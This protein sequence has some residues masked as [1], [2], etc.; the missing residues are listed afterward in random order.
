[1]SEQ[2]DLKAN[3]KDIVK[4][5]VDFKP[6]VDVIPEY[7]P[8]AEDIKK[9]EEEEEEEEEKAEIKTPEIILKLGDVILITDPTNEILNN[10]VFLIEYI[11]PSKIKLI[12]SE[13]YEKTIIQIS[14][15][16]IIGDGNIQAIK[17]ISSNIEE[18]YA[19]QNDLL[20]GTWINIYFGGEIPTVIT[21]EIT[22]LEEDMIEVRTTDDDTLFINFKYQ[23]VPEDI[24]IETFEIRPAIVRKQGI[25]GEQEEQG[26]NEEEEIKEEEPGDQEINELSAL[27]EEDK[28]KAAL[29]YKSEV[30]QKLQKMMFDMSDI[31]FGDIVKVEEYVNIDKSKYRYNIE[32][33]ANDLLEEMVSS[34]PNAKRTNNVLNNI[35]IMISR[36]IQLRQISSTFDI[37]K[38]IT[39][40]I[41]RTANDKPLAEY[42]S[43]F[44]NT[45]YWILLVASNVKK[46]YPSDKKEYKRYTD[47]ELINENVQNRELNSLFRKYKTNQSIE[48]QN[49]YANLY[50]ALDPYMTPFYSINP[51]VVNNVFA[52]TDGIIIEGTVESNVNAVIDNLG[53]LYSTIVSNSQIV[54]RRFVIQR[55]N[56]GQDMLYST[57]L[58]AKNMVAHRVKLTN[59]DPISIKSILTLPEP[60]VRF[61]QINLPGS[62]LLVKANLNLH[63]LN[64]WELLKQKTDI[65]KIVIDGLDNDIEY[66]DD[67]FV[68]NIKQYMLDLT[69]YDKPTE[70]TNLDIYKIFLR[71]IVPKTRV[72]FNLVK[73]YIKGRLSLVDVV[74]YLEPFMI[75][76]ID[77]TYMQ[78]REINS[79][80]SNKIKEY[81][82][83]YKEYSIAFS[84]IKYIKSVAGR[85]QQNKGKYIYSN[86]LFNLLDTGSDMQLKMHI[87]N[88]YGLDEP[89]KMECSG[90][91]LLKKI[92][93]ADY[94]QLYNTAVAL[95][96]IQLMY[97][98][99]LNS[100]FEMDKNE[101]KVLT[102]KDKAN[103][104]CSA[105]IIAKKY[106]SKDAMLADDGKPI[107]FDKEYD[108][109]NYE[110]IEEKYKTQRD[111]LSSEEFIIFL[112]DEFVNKHKMDEKPAEH[113]ATTLVN[114]AKRVREGDY[115]IL[116]NVVEGNYPQSFEYYV[117]KDDTWVLDKEL[118]PDAFIKDDDV[119]CNMDYTCM[120]NPLEKGEDKCDSTEVI[121]D[122]IAS[123]ALKQIL[124][125]FDKS[126]NIS[127]DELNSRIRRQLD[128]FSKSFDKLQQIK[129]TQFFKYNNQKYD[130]GLKI[131]DEVKERIVSPYV[132][133]RDLIMGQNDFVKKQTDIIKFVSLYCREGD[134]SIPN[135]YDGEMENEWWMY[136][137]ETNTQLLPK[138]VYILANTFITRNKDYDDV[139]NDLKRQIGKRSDKGDTWVDENSGEVICYID[140]DVSEGYKDGFADKSRDIIEKDVGE[141][142]LE[143]Q[144]QKQAKR[145]SPEGE[146]VS[147]VVSILSSNMGIDIEQN[148]DF[149]IKIVTELISDTRILEKEPA[150][151]R[152][153]D[154][155]AKKGKKIPSYMTVY[156]STIMYLTLG[157]Y[158][159]AV[160]TSIP[161]IKTRKTAPGC[162]RS[163]NGFPFEGEGD[164][165]GLNYVACVALKSRDTTTIPWNSLPKNEE[166]IATTLKAFIIRYL[167]PYAE[168]EQ[169]IKE[170]T[171]YLLTNPEQDIPEEYSLGKWTNF[172]PPLKQ[173][174]IKH[175]DNI[176]NGFTEELQNELQTG[177]HR[178]L[179][180]MLVLESKIISYSLAIQEAIQKLIEKKDLL[181]SSSGKP[182]MDNACCN[183][184]TTQITTLGYFINEDAS[185]DNYNQIVKKLSALVRD[186]KILTQ[187]AIMLSEVNTKRI[188]PE[189]SNDFSEETIYQAF[190]DLCNFQSSIPLAE[191][192][193]TIC[194]DKPEYLKKS[195]T[196]QEKI[197]KLKRDGRNYTKE[198]FLRLF[199]LVSR[200]NIIRMSMNKKP[201]SCVDDLSKILNDLDVEENETVP[202]ALT[203]K[204]EKLVE[205]YDV[206][207][208][209]DTE[210]MRTLKNYLVNSITAMRK[211]IINFIKSKSK[212]SNLELT[213]IT[214]F[215]NNLSVWRFDENK[216]NENNKITDDGMYNYINFYKNFINLFAAVF[217]STI[218]NKNLHTITIEPHGYWKL[219]EDHERDIIDM[220]ETFYEPINKFYGNNTIN[221]VLYEIKNKC[222]GINL[223]SLNTPA[224][225][226]IKIGD[227]IIYSGFEKRTLTL[228]YEYYFLSILTEYVSL[229]NNKAMIQKTFVNDEDIYSRNYIMDQELKLS[230]DEQE[231]LEGDISKMK[232]DVAK[233]L[234]AYLT[235]MMKSKKT[236]NT[237]YDDIE[238]AVFKLKEAE[239]YSFTDRLKDMTEEERVVDT[240][241]KNYKLGPLYS[242]GTS[243][244]IKTYDPDIFE[245]DKFVANQVSEL[246]KKLN[247]RGVTDDDMDMEMN[248]AIDEMNTDRD[249]ENDLAKDFNNTDDYDDGD[250]WGEEAENNDDYD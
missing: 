14:S 123:N 93:L 114:Q 64:Y 138:F 116:V 81:N 231:Y 113:M 42:L 122:T 191:D 65:T 66:D 111:N 33:Q 104:T 166:K 173:F 170:K 13:T 75:Y 130:L 174:H 126:Y 76:P 141:V 212:A 146:M 124:D 219:S 79:F 118:P 125:Q 233:L 158:L 32:T 2:I 25:N 56:L 83:I 245:H 27:G 150:Y 185:I 249:I 227:K 101:L 92:T 192:L 22:N 78:Y 228:L 100:V 94:G 197:A 73:K 140:N 144:Q 207:M 246:Q 103:D 44:K 167:M 9:V 15:D 24:P 58:K 239:K 226:N 102:E 89:G 193:A 205:S 190:I 36:F 198:Q 52:S 143:K 38:N 5:D 135:V 86:E 218:I 165:S 50:A 112:T 222:R 149:I 199:Q 127:K 217:P 187:G 216:R 132:R 95:T 84:G 88:E 136:C 177:N 142:I 49:K 250:P 172:L 131:A 214:A 6:D 47:Y 152:R 77:L 31:E 159:I 97:P 242:I 26:I 232:Q 3:N 180:K 196:F 107:Y 220:V 183:E 62:N 162:V 208:E 203:Q 69:E 155:A 168:V 80:I 148:R 72:L 211:N 74:N 71:T 184:K 238:D 244:G 96:N 202:K 171:E 188:Y 161:S 215:L 40:V 17:V 129:R 147:N 20:P 12:N 139:L 1:M 82:S 106:Y 43:E 134:P 157:M 186:I 108:A 46:I 8:N 224:P 23:G 201:V 90:S 68:D 91:E 237:S 21:G 53:S 213:N 119:L 209:T 248:D 195:D 176:T 59:N 179:E 87:F 54:N 225:T 45:L 151:K 48:G 234:V 160:Q 156:S 11:D 98:D 137:V 37:N 57:N 182:F 223:L 204:L 221:N 169:K 28:Q 105:Y 61:S 178:Q 120:Y 63:F 19:R 30:K 153:E 200:N 241:L 128:Y 235:I 121:K 85:N 236:I 163:F 18:G 194:I 4:P 189:V 240:I 133:L 39:G 206:T 210:N 164:D 55:Y 243:K 154:D 247:K 10:N 51:E 181:L 7:I 34:I 67:N 60:T 110:I 29:N 229:T 41:K 145:L 230:E 70:L 99:K 117:R 115:A 35:H 109:T 175:L 16:G